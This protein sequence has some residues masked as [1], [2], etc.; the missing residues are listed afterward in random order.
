VVGDLVECVAGE[1][2]Q[3]ARNG[4]KDHQV[5]QGSWIVI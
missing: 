1:D 5:D 4:N 2:H 3:L